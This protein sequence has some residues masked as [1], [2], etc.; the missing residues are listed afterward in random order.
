MA[1]TD[2]AHLAQ[3]DD[4]VLEAWS[5]QYRQ[6]LLKFFERQGAVGHGPDDLV[7]EVFM[8]LANR[9]GLDG[10]E[11]A[12]GYVFRTAWNV[13]NDARRKFKVR[14]GEAHDEFDEHQHSQL[15]GLTPEH[16]LMGKQALQGLFDALYEL[17]ERTRTVFVLY[18]FENFRQTDIAERL[19]IGLSTVEL[20]MTK[21]KRHLLEK[22]LDR[23]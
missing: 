19:G 16:V 18:H 17:P 15:G 14:A 21:A 8:R 5:R 12:D 4:E 6:P 3:P 7:Q 22:G 1:E 11:K 13:L 10:I 20:H 2:K 9:P 23:L